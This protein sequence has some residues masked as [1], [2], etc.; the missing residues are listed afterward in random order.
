MNKK[1]QGSGVP[2][3]VVWLLLA[4]LAFGASLVLVPMIKQSL[5][6]GTSYGSTGLDKD[7]QLEPGKT[8]NL[9]IKADGLKLPKFIILN[10]K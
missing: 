8:K 3:W 4:L 5:G 6:I 7:Q 2:M 10:L 9:I 1:G